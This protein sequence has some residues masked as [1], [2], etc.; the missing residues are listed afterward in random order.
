MSR[1]HQRPINQ[2]EM[3]AK[4]RFE[5]AQP[6]ARVSMRRRAMGYLSGVRMSPRYTHRNES[7]LSLAVASRRAAAWAWH[8]AR[9]V[10]ALSYLLAIMAAVW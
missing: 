8:G 6:A 9:E 10:H 2:A 5:M 3:E 7:A 4:S 1:P